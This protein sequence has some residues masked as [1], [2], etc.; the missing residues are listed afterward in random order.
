MWTRKIWMDYVGRARF[1]YNIATHSAIGHFPFVVV[2]GVL[3]PP[4]SKIKLP[5]NED[6]V[7]RR[8]RNPGEEARVDGMDKDNPARARRVSDV[9]MEMLDQ[10]DDDGNIQ[11][12]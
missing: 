9:H 7:V 6:K 4:P 5:T 8:Q 2:Y 12:A 11:P 1:S 3:T 10:G